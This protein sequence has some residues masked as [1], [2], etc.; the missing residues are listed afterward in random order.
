[1]HHAVRS[2]G[3]VHLGELADG[4]FAGPF[5]VGAGEVDDHA[6]LIHHPGVANSGGD[7]PLEFGQ[8]LVG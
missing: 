8:C 7:H 2:Y 4:W 6:Y 3:S 5:S 1:M